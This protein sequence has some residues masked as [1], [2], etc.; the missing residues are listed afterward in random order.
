MKTKIA[1]VRGK[2]LNKF[3][4]QF[5]EPLV[6]KYQLLGVGSKSAFAHKYKLPVVKL[7][8]PV[9][10]PDFP[11]K[12]PILNR[13]F[14]DANYL[15]GLEK[16]I[17]GY[18]IAHCAESY[19]H[20]TIQCLNA[21]KKGLVKKVVVSIY[22][23]IPF[24]AEG[25]WGRKS[26]KKRVYKES[27][28]IIAVSNKTKSALIKEGV[29]SKKISVITQHINTN[30]FYPVSKKR[31][32]IT[33]LFTGR[34]E[35]YKGVF[36]FMNAAN[37][38]IK[39]KNLK[40]H[41]LT[42]MMVGQGSQKNN[43]IKLQKKLGIEKFFSMTA[44]PYENMPAVYQDADIFIAPSRTTKH[45]QE[46]FSTVLLE[47][48]ASGL[49]IIST[50]TG[51]IPENVGTAGIL[52]KEG[53]YRE[54]ARNA[55]KLILDSDYRVKLGKMARNNAISRFTI[56]KGAQKLDNIYEAVLVS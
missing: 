36:D 12:M 9:D 29:S 20:F 39:D 46:Q 21:K 5:F 22:E 37:I 4:L 7:V 56:N 26:F 52:V 28:H 16:A 27:D 38:L 13:L 34:L 23:N 8:S 10:L 19:Y 43:L 54:I 24:A 48:K 30:I 14:V 45:W 3:E 51:G 44:I 47:A 50:R 53:D 40:D 25:I 33:I 15:Y 32:N 31:N 2:F 49:A 6:S 1:I 55:K 17:E 18:D 11:G 41:K 42:F 35:I